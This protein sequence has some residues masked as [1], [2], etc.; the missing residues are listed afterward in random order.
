MKRCVVVLLAL[1]AG[2]AVYADEV[3]LKLDP[4]SNDSVAFAWTNPNA[5][6]VAEALEISGMGLNAFYGSGAFAPLSLAAEEAGL[7]GNEPTEDYLN[8]ADSEMTHI[9]QWG[10]ESRLDFPQTALF[11]L[12]DALGD[13]AGVPQSAMI[14]VLLAAMGGSLAIRRCFS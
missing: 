1:F 13:Q 7:V 2:M 4:V 10:H 8:W 6:L 14:G 11:K 3:A 5:G 9:G 12:E